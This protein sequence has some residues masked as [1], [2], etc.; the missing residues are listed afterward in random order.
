MMVGRCVLIDE[1]QL[2][3]GNLF[4]FGQSCYVVPL[5]GPI[6]S[7]RQRVICHV[8]VPACKGLLI[9]DH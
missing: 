1:A 4:K 2:V 7:A 6:Q 3:L 5:L 8:E 9:D